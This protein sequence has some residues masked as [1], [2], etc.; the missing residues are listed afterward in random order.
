MLAAGVAV[1]AV[2]PA[3]AQTAD[4]RFPFLLRTSLAP[5]S[6]AVLST[7]AQEVAVSASVPIPRPAPH[8]GTRSGPPPAAAAANEPQSA[9]PAASMQVAYAAQPSEL[10]TPFS[11]LLR[12]AV[13]EP[14]SHP[15]SADVPRP[16]AAIPDRT[17]RPHLDPRARRLGE[18]ISAEELV[19]LIE[20]KAITHGVPLDLAHAVVRVESNYSAGPTGR[21]GTLGLM[22]IKYNT[23]RGLGFTGSAQDL[24][25]PATNLEW[26]MRYLAQAYKLGRGDLCRTVLKYQSGHRA[27]QM[28]KVAAAYCGKVKV[29]MAAKQ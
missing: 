26:G 5:A 13:A 17:A 25:D 10:D 7:S 27:V 9:A 21:G 3:C 11:W 1:A 15:A 18:P 6:E 12:Q 16:P 28:N 23:A 29:L 20:N 14:P 8:R 19:V 2:A 4:E 22:Q 24:L